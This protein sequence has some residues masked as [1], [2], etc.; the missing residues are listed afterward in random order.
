MG[1]SQAPGEVLG[2]GGHNTSSEKELMSF[3]TFISIYYI[4][5]YYNIYKYILYQL[6]NH[7]GL[8]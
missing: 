5:I 7:F 1:N 4:Y 8:T 2:L 3:L 6:I